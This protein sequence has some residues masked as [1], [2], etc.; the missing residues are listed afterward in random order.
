MPL[1]YQ[2]RFKLSPFIITLLLSLGLACGLGD[3]PGVIG[4]GD[5][6]TTTAEVDLEPSTDGSTGDNNATIEE[7]AADNEDSG[8]CR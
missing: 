5:E 8:C 2:K 1:S 4:G 7:S 3:L 6:E